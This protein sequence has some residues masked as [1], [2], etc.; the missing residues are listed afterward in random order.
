MAT[1]Y[2]VIIIGTGHL[3]C[4]HGTRGKDLTEPKA[5]KAYKYMALTHDPRI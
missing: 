1:H 3:H 2:D 5:S 4:E